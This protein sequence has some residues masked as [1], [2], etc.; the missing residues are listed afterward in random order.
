MAACMKMLHAGRQLHKYSVLVVKPKLV[1]LLRN[2]VR[3]SHSTGPSAL[4]RRHPLRFYTSAGTSHSTCRLCVSNFGTTMSPGCSLTGG[5]LRWVRV[6]SV[7]RCQADL[8]S[9]TTPPYMMQARMCGNRSSGTGFSG[10]DGGESSAGDDSGGDGGMSP[11]GPQMTA[12][13]P[14]MVPEVFPNVPLIAVS[15]NPVFP[16]FIKIIEV[17]MMLRPFS[18]LILSY[19]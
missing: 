14:M 16:R 10:E 17:R 1:A 9:S 5:S 3:F 4:S 11:E 19:L 12:L 7:L 15:R 13:T 6:G 2:S 8:L 18:R